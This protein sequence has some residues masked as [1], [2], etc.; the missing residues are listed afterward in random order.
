MQDN[1]PV[2][3][4]IIRENITSPIKDSVNIVAENSKHNSHTTN[5]IYI[6]LK[7]LFNSFTFIT[8]NI[9]THHL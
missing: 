1:T 2:P 7:F 5:K 8:N 6:V 3:H 4:D 9:I